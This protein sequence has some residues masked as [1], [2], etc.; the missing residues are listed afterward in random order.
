M[1]NRGVM[2]RE[3]GQNLLGCFDAML[4]MPST[5]QRFSKDYASMIRSFYIPVMVFPLTI[6]PSV[7]VPAVASEHWAVGLPFYSL[8]VWLSL[9]V[10]LA[11][12]SYIVRETGRREHFYQFVTAYNWLALPSAMMFL[13]ALWMA[14]SGSPKE[15]V[16]LMTCMTFY[17]YGFTAFAAAS[18]LRIPI[19]LGI[20]IVVLAVGVDHGATNI[21]S[22]IQNVAL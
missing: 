6:L 3:I 14:A 19:E 12:M 7:F 8:K 15:A 5:G 22:W 11:I 1:K 20:S 21:M 18:V 10:F 16:A 17:C 13:P 9:G 4:L 2:L